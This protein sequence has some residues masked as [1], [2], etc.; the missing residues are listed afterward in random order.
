MAQ[1]LITVTG[2]RGIVLILY[3][4]GAEYH[5]IQAKHGQDVYIDSTA[6]DVSY[7][8]LP[9]NPIPDATA[10]SSCL[11]ITN[12]TQT[13]YEVKWEYDDDPGTP[14]PTLASV[15]TG[16]KID[17]LILDD[18]V[19]LT[20][21]II[22]LPL[23]SFPKARRLVQEIN[24]LDDPRFRIV[25]TTRTRRLEGPT[26]PPPQILVTRY[27][28]ILQMIGDLVPTIRV[29]NAAN[30][31]YTNYTGTSSICLPADYQKIKSTC[32]IDP[33]TKK[34]VTTPCNC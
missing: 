28:F 24:K 9:S 6:T 5:S 7:T 33:V 2:S 26:P 10:T 18:S 21:E 1:C 19:L 20:T 17:A 27:G 4:L 12:K 11:T 3:K 15:G 25:A 22:P 32:I 14:R 31:G 13:C 8:V 34:K 29:R 30:T 23:M 16:Q